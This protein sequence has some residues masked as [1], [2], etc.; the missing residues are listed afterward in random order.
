MLM[1]SSWLHR[2]CDSLARS[3]FLRARFCQPF[4]SAPPLP[5]GFVGFSPLM[6]SVWLVPFP[7][8]SCGGS[9]LGCAVVPVLGAL[10]QSRGW[11]PIVEAP[12]YARH[13]TSILAIAVVKSPRGRGSR[14]AALTKYL[15][16]RA[17]TRCEY[18]SFGLLAQ[19]GYYATKLPSNTKVLHLNQ[20]NHG[21]GK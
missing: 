6:F 5:L 4:S 7:F 3:V 9:W 12:G 2:S 11:L 20:A 17:Q 21:R 14:G 10:L 18:F 8:L 13:P 15:R 1:P 16:K 19:E